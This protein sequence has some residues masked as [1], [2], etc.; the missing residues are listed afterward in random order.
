M[1][2]VIVLMLLVSSFGFAKDKEEKKVTPSVSKT[3][4]R[5]L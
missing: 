2:K 5:R 3:L 1:K 4:R